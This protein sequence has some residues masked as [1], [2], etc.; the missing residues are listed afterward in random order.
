MPAVQTVGKPVE[1][2]RV[3]SRVAQKYFE[4]ALSSRVFIEDGIDLFPNRSEH[5]QRR[6]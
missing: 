4:D 6:R 1:Q 3:E 2:D 5:F